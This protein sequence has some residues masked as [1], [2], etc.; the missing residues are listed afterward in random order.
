MLERTP[1]FILHSGEPAEAGA[2]APEA[3]E[4]TE[5]LDA[6][7]RAVSGVVDAVGPAPSARRSC[8]S[9]AAVATAAA[10]SAPA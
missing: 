6:Y 8:G 9:K 5:L 7:S 1:Q 10:A 4:D 2:P 3:I